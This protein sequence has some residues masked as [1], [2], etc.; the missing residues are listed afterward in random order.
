MDGPQTNCRRLGSG[1]EVRDSLSFSFSFF[2]FFFFFFFFLGL[3]P[4]LAFSDAPLP[5]SFRPLW[6][7]GTGFM[8]PTEGGEDDLSVDVDEGSLRKR[9]SKCC[10]L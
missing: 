3:W 9:Q 5:H 1:M 4:L 2:F 7:V 10:E 6:V 8:L